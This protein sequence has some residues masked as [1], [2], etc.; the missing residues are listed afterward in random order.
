MLHIQVSC[1]PPDTII[2]VRDKRVLHYRAFTK[3]KWADT[4]PSMFKLSIGYQQLLTAFNYYNRNYPLSSNFC[5][6][7][8][9]LDPKSRKYNE[10]CPSGE[11]ARLVSPEGTIH[12]L[13]CMYSASWNWAVHILLVY[14]WAALTSGFL[15]NETLKII[16]I[17]D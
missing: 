4:M 16:N 1:L 3:I 7:Q 9:I 14:R 11:N 13:V 6:P 10:P 17:L 15:V 2:W 5:K 8:V 12:K